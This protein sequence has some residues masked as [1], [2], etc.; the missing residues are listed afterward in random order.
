MGKFVNR[1]RM[2]VSG[3]PGTGPVT[4]LAADT[5]A[6]TFANTGISD[7]DSDLPY[8]LESGDKTVWEYG[9]GTYA[10]AGPT[11]T[12]TTVVKS[13]AGVGVAANFPAGTKAT[14]VPQGSDIGNTR[15]QNTWAKAQTFTLAPVFS[16]LSGYLKGNGASALTA[17][18]AIPLGDIS[19]LGTGVATALAIAL[20]SVGGL[21]T[22]SGSSGQMQY[23]AA[24]ALA[25]AN[26]WRESADVIALR[27]AANAQMLRIY[28][29]YTDASNYERVSLGFAS[30]EAVLNVEAAGTGTVRAL[31]F[32]QAGATIALFKDSNLAFGGGAMASL[33]SGTWNVAVGA[34]ALA[35]LTTG[36][37]NMAV[38][39][40]AL[41][42]LTTG[43][44]NVA[45]GGVA[46]WHATTGNNNVAIGYG[47]LAAVGAGNANVGIGQGAG[48]SGSTNVSIGQ[49]AGSLLTGN[50]NTLIGEG[51]GY[52]ITS[53]AGNTVIGNFGNYGS[54]IISGDC[55]I[56]IGYRVAVPSATANYQLC[57]GNLIYGTDLDGAGATIS[58]GN[59]GIGTKAPAGKLDVAGDLVLSGS[60][61]LYGRISGGGDQ[62][63]L[64]LY[65]GTRPQN[66]NVYNT[67]TDASNLER[68]CI[69]YDDGIVG[70]WYE[71][72]GTGVSRDFQLFLDST[73]SCMWIGL[74]KGSLA[75]GDGAH[76][77]KG[78]TFN[79][80]IG[81][82]AL[83][84][85][86]HSGTMYNIAIGD[87]AMERT[88]TNN[89]S[90]AIGAWALRY[91]TDGGSHVAIG[92]DTLEYCATGV[93][94]V[95]IGGAAAYVLDGD[96]NVIIGAEAVRQAATC[97]SD[98]NTVI[99]FQ[100][101]Y[102]MTD[103]IGQNTLIGVYSGYDLTT[104]AYNV[105]IGGL[106]TAQSVTTGNYNI[107]IGY[108]V[109]VPSVAA[110]N[111]LSIGNLIYGTDLDGR[112]TTISSGKIGIGTKTPAA[113]LDVAGDIALYGG[114]G[115]GGGDGVLSIKNA[116]TAPTTDPS[117][118]GILYVES[119]A[120]KFRGSGGTV[121]TIANA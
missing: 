106:S 110:D 69:A 11:L 105:L 46:M 12:R 49:Y 19:G 63:I 43:Y 21:V 33:T 23:N 80:A 84:D 20:N 41:N 22:A 42:E 72:Y 92:P 57:I 40:Y 60:A 116:A 101:G 47:A 48:S 3:A 67:R 117:D 31:R 70:L 87:R 118:G 25:A 85:A 88:N 38:G 35:S 100:A 83:H 13:S 102:K 36:Y 77:N 27:N 17:V 98:Y 58:S 103:G 108:D 51:A 45:V 109:T 39:E 62:D 6:E 73:L 9:R 74:S 53:G 81:H 26:L 90:V 61:H 1:A 10:A 112:S 55:N 2:T 115:F 37:E 111:Q 14:L 107:A 16:A 94:N 30:N 7:G 50:G 28:N 76:V 119:G 121:T 54:P 91:A 89:N 97:A 99:G 64:E 24:G 96:G 56:L 32:R 18:A 104:G 15:E 86:S 68:F 34:G 65:N 75:F 52:E 59:I 4:L 71:H 120:L 79:V 93:K 44:N 95:A 29:T 66:F 114:A 78:G 113:K 5:G 8:L 82:N